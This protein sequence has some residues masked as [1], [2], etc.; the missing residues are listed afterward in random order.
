[1]LD[2]AALSF[3]SYPVKFPASL[4]QLQL[5]SVVFL[6]L[7]ARG[8]RDE[9]YPAFLGSFIEEAFNVL[10]NSRC[11]LINESIFRLLSNIS[12]YIKAIYV[13][14]AHVIE[15]SRQTDSLLLTTTQDVLP[16]LTTVPPILPV[17]KISQ[18]DGVQY[19]F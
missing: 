6:E 17:W 7:C 8:Y 19:S 12:S 10:G 16:F 14:G 4:I 9:G 1:M 3:S 13:G 11:S 5:E 15:K 18:A 2:A